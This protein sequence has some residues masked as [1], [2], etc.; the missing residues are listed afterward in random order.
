MVA[1]MAIDP[2]TPVIVGVGQVDQRPDDQRLEALAQA[3]EPYR[4]MSRAS[5][6]AFSDSGAVDAGDAVDLIA[7]VQGAWSYTDPGRLI[8]DGL[9]IADVRTAVTTMGGQA[10]QSALN[11]IFTR[12]RRGD[13]RAA[14]V[15][16]GETIWSR[17]K[18]RARGERLATTR[19]TDAEPDEVLGH[20]LTMST[21][22][23]KA[24]GIDQPPI[25]YAIFE[26][27]I[28]AANGES[29]DDHRR[30]LGVLWAGFNVVAVAN[31]HAWIRRPMTATEI[32]TAT[33]DN[34]MVGFPY[35]KAMNSNWYLDQASAVFVASVETAERLGV[36]RDRWIFPW[37]GASANDTPAV[38]NRRDL[39]SSPAIGA[40][41]DALYRHGGVGPDD[42][43][44]VDLYSCFPSAVQIG[45][46]EFGLGL[47]RRLTVTGGLTFAGGPLNN[48]VGHSVATMVEALREN[49][50]IGLVTANGGY[51][52]RHSAALY[53]SDPPPTPFVDFDVQQTADRAAHVPA[54][55]DFTGRGHIEGYTVMHHRSEPSEALV[56][57]LTPHGGRTWGRGRD[58]ATNAQL[59]STEAVGRPVRVGSR[60]QIELI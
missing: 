30:R 13:L 2:R 49:P 22:F 15:T 4:L 6:R 48:Y 32:V 20:E 3:E 5:R 34:R 14:V 57:I 8:A 28:R 12:I 52:T 41:A 19:Q 27:A 7:V 42:L 58:Q 40:I 35:T 60:G 38:T 11:T 36:S 59:M 54:A 29:I 21:P 23:E 33:A 53:R 18:L 43:D 37:V 9:G 26:S 55:E 45:A 47:D 24:R 1:S 44:H 25:L 46:A 39:H 51:L 17:Q 16:G 50:G 31:E 10:P 56:A